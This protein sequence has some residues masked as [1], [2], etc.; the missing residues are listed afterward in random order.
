MDHDVIL[1]AVDT[2]IVF[3]PIRRDLS[4]RIDH[5]VPVGKLKLD[6]ILLVHSA[7]DDA[8]TLRRI[9]R[10]T[11]WILFMI[12]DVHEDAAAVE[13]RMTSIKLRKRA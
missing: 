7:V 1:L 8:P 11:H 5:D 9:D 6:L 12:Y 3:S 2:E 10:E 13:I 4:R